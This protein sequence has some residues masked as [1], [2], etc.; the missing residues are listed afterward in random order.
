MRSTCPHATGHRVK[1]GAALDERKRCPPTEQDGCPVPGAYPVWTKQ[2]GEGGR[3]TA[4]HHHAYRHRTP[5][6]AYGHCRA[7]NDVAAT[8]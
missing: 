7:R 6:A 2:R 3:P 4:T 1:A 8:Q 5:E